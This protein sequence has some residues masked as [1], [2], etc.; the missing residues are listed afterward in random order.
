MLLSL[1][2][3]FVTAQVTFTDVAVQMGVNDVGAAQGV[4][5]L[6]VNND[7]YLDIYLVNNANANR[8][9]INNNGTSFT[10]ASAIWGVNNNNAGRGCSAADYNNDGLIDIVIGNY[11][12][13]LILYKNIGSSF[14]NFTTNAGLSFMS[15]GG[16]V[17]WFDYNS[18][19]KIDF[20]FANDGIPMHYNYLFKNLDLISFSNVAYQS[21]LID[22]TSTLC[23]ATGDYDN[24]GDIDIYMGT[25]TNS[26]LNGTGFLYKNNGNGTFAD[27]TIASGLV[28]VYYNWGA[29][30][31][32]YNNDGYLDLFLANYTGLNQ[33]FKNNGNGTFTD[34]GTSMGVADAGNS[35]S[36]G[37]ADYDN[38]G[39][40]DLYV[41]KAQNIQDKLYR[42]D[43]TIFTDVSTQAGMGDLR[44]SSCISW[45]DFN[46]DGFLDL[47]L[48][49]NGTENRLYQSNAGNSNKWIIL[50]MQGVNSC[51]SAVGTR[52]TIKTGSLTQIREVEGGSG[53]KGQN[54]L[55]IEFGLGT[56][57]IIDTLRVKWT[58]GLVQNFTN[59]QP[60]RIISIIEGQPLDITSENK[61]IP[62]NYKLQQNYP[63]PFNPET[64][65]R[66][67]IPK[68]SFV[69]L[70]IFDL[71]G[72]EVRTVVNKNLTAGEY[73][74]N[75]N[76]ENLNSGIYFYKLTAG[77][78][79][80]TKKMLMIK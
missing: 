70:K 29:E 76:S 80:Q 16:S 32:D 44:H 18:D 10:D 53:G 40:L 34:V 43:G 41:A 35:Y 12:Q 14:V 67:E 3:T 8:L 38:D 25:Q 2:L 77:N 48:N 19:G 20:V 22:S 68:S 13:N 15:W 61:N 55:P 46:N 65:I 30:W 1:P 23:I 60:N 33:L 27:V 59:V 66:F 56:A 31:G 58:S 47:Y 69:S 79:V 52:V 78:F 71:L 17:N 7:N 50:K 74:F 37:W 57:S 36:C 6:D 75:F 73:E 26:G 64:K 21:G 63:N 24:D 49:N 62:A 45:G 5:F 4:V 72:K 28:T 54:S 51:R 42:N 39:D 9:W 11:N